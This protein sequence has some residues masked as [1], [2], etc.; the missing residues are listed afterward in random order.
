MEV[1]FLLPW[2]YHSMARCTKIYKDGLWLDNMTQ[3]R[4]SLSLFTCGTLNKLAPRLPG[5]GQ[6]C[7]SQRHA[8]SASIREYA[9]WM[10]DDDLTTDDLTFHSG[11]FEVRSDCSV[12]S[13][14]P[15]PSLDLRVVQGQFID[16]NKDNCNLQA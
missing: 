1:T 2:H 16:K 6:D 9:G 14:D 3:S 12:A 10:D 5:P 8:F 11:A 7:K 13:V 15:Q 4:K